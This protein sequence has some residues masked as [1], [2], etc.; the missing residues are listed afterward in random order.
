MKK[1]KINKQYLRKITSPEIKP[2]PLDA[3]DFATTVQRFAKD[4]LRGIMTVEICGTPSG[5]VN[6]NIHVTSYLIR[7][8]CDGIDD[9]EMVEV[10]FHFDDE[11]RIE[12]RFKQLPDCDAT[13]YMVNVAKLAGFRVS[14]DNETLFF[15]AKTDISST[16]KIYANSQNLFLD[17]LIT[18]YN[19]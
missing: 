15:H 10:I 12:A 7:L 14:R 9:D 6:V 1:R 3:L 18:T 16:M 17:L 19:M 11:M 13:G 8:L 2:T 5:R 4:Y